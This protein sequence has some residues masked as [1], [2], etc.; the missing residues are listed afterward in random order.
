[1]VSELV[2]NTNDVFFCD[3]RGANSGERSRYIA[4][5]GLASTIL[6]FVPLFGHA[7]TA[8]G[9]YDAYW[10]VECGEEIADVVYPNRTLRRTALKNTFNTVT[11]FRYSLR[12]GFFYARFATREGLPD[13]RVNLSDI[14]PNADYITIFTKQVNSGLRLESY[15]AFE[16]QLSPT[17]RYKPSGEIHSEVEELQDRC[18]I[19]GP[20]GALKKYLTIGT[21]LPHDYTTVLGNQPLDEARGRYLLLIQSRIPQPDPITS[22]ELAT[23]DPDLPYEY[24]W[25]L[26]GKFFNYILYDFLKMK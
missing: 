9:V 4:I 20:P 7:V 10:P 5:A 12:D 17:D 2:N 3:L 15:R 6:S 1:M 8:S 14:V 16:L 22:I 25:I 26:R 21:H 11:L 13:G 19:S 24:L 23:A 18:I